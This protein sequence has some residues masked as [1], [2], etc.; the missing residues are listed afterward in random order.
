[1]PSDALTR[2]RLT[3]EAECATYYNHMIFA[4]AFNISSDIMLLC[5][6]IPI[7]V[8]SRIPM[9][10]YLPFVCDHWNVADVSSGAA[11]R[12]CCAVCWVSAVST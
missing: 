9:K 8:R 6:P 7:V 12:L 3:Y 4:T 2:R 10:R 5:I 1:V 11:E